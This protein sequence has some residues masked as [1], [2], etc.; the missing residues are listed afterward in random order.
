[1]VWVD[2]SFTPMLARFKKIFSRENVIPK[3]AGATN[4]PSKVSAIKKKNTTSFQVEANTIHEDFP[5]FNVAAAIPGKSK[6]DEFVVFSAHY[7]YIGILDRVV[8]YSIATVAD[9]VASGT[10]A[11]LDF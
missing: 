1:M 11:I 10:T 2:P 8:K 5:L 3:Q 6:A 9:D 4:G 7:Y